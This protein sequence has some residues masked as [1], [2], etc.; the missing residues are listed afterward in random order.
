MRKVIERFR[1]FDRRLRRRVA[2]ACLIVLA[3]GIGQGVAHH[4]DDGDSGHTSH[5]CSVCILSGLVAILATPF[6]LPA[7]GAFQVCLNANR[8]SLGATFSRAYEARGPPANS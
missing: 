2:F 1:L 3:L 4:A 6:V 8:H 7:R 5:E